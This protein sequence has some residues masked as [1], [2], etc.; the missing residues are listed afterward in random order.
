MVS[1]IEEHDPQRL[2]L[3]CNLDLFCIVVIQLTWLFIILL[4]YGVFMNKL[5]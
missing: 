3:G 4:F 2:T 5:R 1:I